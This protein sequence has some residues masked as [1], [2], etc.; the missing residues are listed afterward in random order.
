MD[1]EWVGMY[2]LLDPHALR[3][4]LTQLKIIN[5]GAFVQK[6]EGKGL[7]TNDYT[8]EEKQKLG[9]VESGAQ[10]NIIESIDVDNVVLTPDASKN[11]HIDLSGKVDVVPGKGLSTNDYTNEEKQKLGNVESGAQVNVVETIKVNNV[12]LTPDANKA[13]NID[14]SGKADLNSPSFTGTPTAPNVLVSDDSTKIANTAFVKDAIEAALSGKIDLHFLFL[15]ELP[16]TGVVGTF[17]FIPAEDPETG[18]DEWEEYVWDVENN[19]FERIGSAKV[20]LT[21]Y[22]NKTNLP[23]ITDAQIDAILA[24]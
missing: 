8:N 23:A 4:L 24:S 17:Y 10:V 9:N 1:D 15:S 5:E 21:D 13:V 11:I 19:R 2:E 16:S 12:T 22:F 3:Y 7:S 20:D 14:I 18:I 6:I